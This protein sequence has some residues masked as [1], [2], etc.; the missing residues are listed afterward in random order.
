MA[1]ESTA[2][3]R[4]YGLLPNTEYELSA[5]VR[6]EDSR[7]EALLGVK[8]YGGEQKSTRIAGDA[9]A[10]AFARAQVRFR[11]GARDTSAVVFCYRPSAGHAALFDDV[12][13]T[14]LETA[15]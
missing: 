1:A 9:F 14:R 11:T 12:A 3:H 4:L 8:E 7:D 2:Q 15:P 5:W 10:G 6:L 13:L